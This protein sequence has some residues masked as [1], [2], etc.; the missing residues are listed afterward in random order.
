MDAQAA[1]G[2]GIRWHRD[3][4]RLGAAR[5]HRRRASLIGVAMLSRFKIPLIAMCLSVLGACSDRAPEPASPR[6]PPAT[7]EAS[8]TKTH[9]REGA[10]VTALLGTWDYR[11]QGPERRTILDDFE[12][13]IKRADR[14]VV[15]LAFVD[16][17][18]W[19]LG[20]LFDGELLLVDG[21][22]EGDAGPYTITGDRLT[23]IGSHAQA[24]ITYTWQL[25]G[26]KLTLSAI[27][28]CAITAAAP[29]RCTRN[30]RN[31]DPLMRLVTE[32]T[33]T[34]SGNDVTY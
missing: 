14:V 32:H 10:Q 11:F 3:G 13:Y 33:Y 9:A 26:R 18:N 4:D 8:P 27:E 22:P 31:M 12:A 25:K 28:E 2:D 1:T 21:V 17:D 15:R 6:K 34:R 19:W 29:P 23:T 30:R 24:R 5:S 20:F 7:I 16:E